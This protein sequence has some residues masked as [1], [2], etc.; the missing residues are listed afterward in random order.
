MRMTDGE[1]KRESGGND[2]SNGEE[3]P[4]GAMCSFLVRACLSFS[5]RGFSSSPRALCP[6]A[7]HAATAI[8]VVVVVVA[9]PRASACAS[10]IGRHFR[11]GPASR[12]AEKRARPAHFSDRRDGRRIVA[13][14]VIV[15]VVRRRCRFS[16]W[17]PKPSPR[18]SLVLSS[19]RS[20]SLFFSLPRERCSLSTVID[21]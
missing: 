11:A 7:T 8:V 17:R 3:S 14:V 6:Y 15:I 1:R 16:S 13:V 5:R 19:S 9:S 4:C 2:R 12:L 21:R 18:S 10:P 20:I